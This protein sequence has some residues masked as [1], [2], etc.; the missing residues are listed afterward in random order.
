MAWTPVERGLTKCCARVR[1]QQTLHGTAWELTPQPRNTDFWTVWN[2]KSSFTRRLGDYLRVRNLAL[3]LKKSSTACP[4]LHLYRLHKPPTHRSFM[5]KVMCTRANCCLLLH[6]RLQKWGGTACDT[7][8]A[9]FIL[10]I[11]VRC[12]DLGTESRD[13]TDHGR[14]IQGN[15]AGSRRKK[16]ERLPVITS[17]T[18]RS[19]TI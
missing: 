6:W 5:R 18:E 10:L 8:A 16:K 12:G 19:R 7:W 11:T 14:E 9:R 15:G 2:Q 1:T 4:K 13:S 17:I 3:G